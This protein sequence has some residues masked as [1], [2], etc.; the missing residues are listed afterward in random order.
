MKIELE[1]NEALELL[2]LIREKTE[3]IAD[4]RQN[5]IEM[6]ASGNLDEFELVIYQ[7]SLEYSNKRLS[8]ISSV[9]QKI[10]SEFVK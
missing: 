7:A 9:F 5:T 1:T 4:A 8:R 10:E 3:E 2:K 6:L